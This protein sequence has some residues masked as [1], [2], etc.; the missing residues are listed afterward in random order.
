MCRS[1]SMHSSFFVYLL[2]FSVTGVRNRGT[3]AVFRVT[4]RVACVTFREGKKWLNL[5]YR[6]RGSLALSCRILSTD[7]TE[8]VPAA[9]SHR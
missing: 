3:I 7:G 6:R 9:R 8:I 1:G 5:T 2:G 4:I